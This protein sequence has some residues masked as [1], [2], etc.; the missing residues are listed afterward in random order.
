MTDLPPPRAP[1]DFD[2]WYRRVSSS[3]ESRP[4][5]AVRRAV[6]DHATKLA[7]IHASK[8]S[9]A[10][11]SNRRWGLWRWRGPAVAGTLAAA[12]SA[13]MLLPRFLP[14]SSPPPGEDVVPALPA[15]SVTEAHLADQ[16]ASTPAAEP[17]TAEPPTRSTEAPTAAQAPAG[18]AEA[19]AA[20]VASRPA[21]PLSYTETAGRARSQGAA[22]AQTDARSALND[23]PTVATRESRFARQS[24]AEPAQTQALGIIPERSQETAEAPAAAL[25]RAAEIG[26]VAALET[27]LQKQV[28]I[29]SR[30]SL[31]RT[32]LMLAT[33][34]GQIGTATALLG[35]GADP[36]AA[37]ARGTTPLE[38]ARAGDHPDIAAALERYGAR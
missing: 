4:S 17:P 33:L 25:R 23:A 29:D 16:V 5:E 3:D 13:V 27:L 15:R 24:I 38:A 22:R 32:A 14:P 36:N 18:S 31:G 10:S 8:L 26:D 9:P 6:L 7:A 1:D 11:T 21:P 34:R 37:D 28:N 20:K 2:D 19:P 35:H 12:L 30:D